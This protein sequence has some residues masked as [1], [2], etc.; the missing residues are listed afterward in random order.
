[1][2]DDT[3]SNGTD[4]QRIIMEGNTPN[5]SRTGTVITRM[6]GDTTVSGYSETLTEIQKIEDDEEEVERNKEDN[7][8]R[9][10]NTP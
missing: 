1:M 9:Q 10:L 6:R 5:A 4:I 8:L 2:I 3:E 7:Y